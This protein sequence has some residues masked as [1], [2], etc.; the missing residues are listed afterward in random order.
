MPMRSTD[1]ILELMAKEERRLA[2]EKGPSAPAPSAIFRPRWHLR[3]KALTLVA[4]A[5]VL[6]LLA[7]LYLLMRR[8]NPAHEIYSPKKEQRAP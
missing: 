7:S 4:A 8:P 5:V 3:S 1:E 2:A 6:L